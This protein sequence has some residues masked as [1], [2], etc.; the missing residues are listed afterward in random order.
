MAGRERLTRRQAADGSIPY[1][2]MVGNEGRKFK[3]WEQYHTFQQQVNHELPDM[4]TEWKD[5]PRDEVGFGQAKDQT[6]VSENLKHTVASVRQAASKAVKLAVL[7]LGEKADEEVIETQA[8]AF[9]AMGDEQLDASLNRFAETEHL[10]QV[11]AGDDE[12][13]E[14][15]DDDKEA[16]VEAGD[17]EEEEEMDDDKEASVEK[18]SAELIA[19]LQTEL[20][21]M[22]ADFAKQAEEVEA[23]DDEEEEEMDDEKEASD[24]VADLQ[25][26]LAEYNKYLEAGKIP[27]QFLENIKKKKEESDDDGDDK[28]A[29][30][31]E[32]KEAETKEVESSEEKEAGK[33]EDMDDKEMDDDK[34]A[35]E[36][37]T[38]GL[39]V[40][41]N[42]VV[43]DHENA[44]ESEETLASLFDDD[45]PSQEDLNKLASE[46]EGIKSLGGQP[47]VASAKDAEENI[48]SI[49][50]DAP[51]VSGVF[52]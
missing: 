49:W 30:N 39:D 38:N 12:E 48:S 42:S 32:S 10:Y 27:P 41:L 46:K 3:T 51:D 14:E 11:E 33:D 20:D 18:S 36:E 34:E 2:G 15:M 52:R 43:A 24:K 16:S 22:K 21:A 19:D 9:L 25:A 31:E 40:E 28:E 8:R 13:E 44:P 37:I 1:P 7:L 29:S 50:N 47:K 45:T 5:N 26:Q 6:G 35:S 17:D 23:G 4:R